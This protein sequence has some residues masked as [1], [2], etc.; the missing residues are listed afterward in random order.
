MAWIP[1]KLTVDE[2][3]D[4]VYP[5]TVEEYENGEIVWNEEEVEVE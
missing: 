3:A 2:V 4:H 5:L 1:I